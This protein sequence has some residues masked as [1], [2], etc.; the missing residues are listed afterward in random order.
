MNILY[1]YVPTWK[2]HVL[3]LKLTPLIMVQLH[4]YADESRSG[5]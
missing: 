3:I 5:I 2:Y 1:F 4:F